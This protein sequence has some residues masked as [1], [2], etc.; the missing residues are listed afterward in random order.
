[1]AG[2]IAK[3]APTKVP[4]KYVDFAVSPDLVSELPKRIRIND[5]A[6]ELV[7]GQQPPYGP[8]YSFRPVGLKGL[9]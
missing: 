7:N 1:M 2:L 8:I 5:H 6:I 9:H 3:K 4:N